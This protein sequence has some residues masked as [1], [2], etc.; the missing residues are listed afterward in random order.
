VNAGSLLS[1]FTHSAPL[2]ESLEADVR[3]ALAEDIGSGD[4]TAEL[5]DPAKQAHAE[6][7]SRDPGVFC[8][9]PWVSAICAQ[10]PAPVAVTWQVRDGQTIDPNTPLFCLD[11][12]ARALLTL[13][14]TLLNFVQLLSGTAT[15]TQHYVRRI[16]AFPTRLLDTRKTIPGL[17]LG[18]KYAVHCGGGHNHRVGL[19]D[20]F[21]L[22]E[23]HL[24]A[25]GGIA[26]A[27]TS[28]RS[29][30]PGMPVEVEVENLEELEQAVAAG[31]D[32]ALIDNFS[33][34]DTRAA[35]AL[36][37]QRI[38]LEASGGITEDDIT[39]IAATGVDYISIGIIT[40]QIIPLDLS[41]RFID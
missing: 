30:H 12:S 27:V 15:V 7:I 29:T 33:L 18:Q 39:E 16:Q 24:N 3:R 38:K 26:Q 13:E 32:I 17:R 41:L 4:I 9:A 21:L 1:S 23:N 20:A 19:F 2:Q 34:T 14:R 10:A 37:A 36:A 40:K 28:A 35:V 5:I 25:A 11:G 8:G 22:K 6:V 31:A